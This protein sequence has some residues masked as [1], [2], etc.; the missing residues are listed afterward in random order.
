MR[1]V[2]RSNAPQHRTAL[3]PVNLK[4]AISVGTV[5]GMSEPWTIRL[6][7][8]VR[9][10]AQGPKQRSTEVTDGGTARDLPE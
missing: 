7:A 1:K 8:L 10:A 4:R 5:A 6:S 3:L 2:R 9:S